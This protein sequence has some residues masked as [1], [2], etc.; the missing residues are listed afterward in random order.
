[1]NRT[2]RKTPIKSDKQAAAIVQK[3]TKTIVQEK[4]IGNNDKVLLGI[5]G[6]IDSTAL[7]FV[8]LEIQKTIDFEL[9]LAHIN[10]MLRSKES[11]RDERF[12]KKLAGRLRL[13]LYIKRVDIKKIAVEKGLSI[14]HAGR[15]ARYHFFNE[16]ITQ[17]GYDK[18]AI[19]H[20][21]D[22]QIETMLL[23]AL[24]GTGLRGLS[25]IPIKRNEIIR[26]FLNTYRTDIS[27]YAS[28]HS[29]LFVED[30]SNDKIVY[31][32]NFL[33]KEIFP[34]MEKLNPLFKEKLSF[35]LKDLT[36]IDHLFEEKSKSFLKKHQK[37]KAG[38]I[39]LDVLSLNKIDDETKFRVISDIIAS[40]EPAFVP[41]R[42]HIHQIKNIL[43]AKKPNLVATLPNGIKIKKIYDHLLFTKKPLSS[44][45]QET[46]L[47]SMGKNV[48][49]PFALNLHLS[50]P[51]K[52]VR[53]FSKNNNIALFD[54]EKLGNLTIRTFINGD[55][56]IPL[57]MKGKMKLKDFFI[58]SKIPK[59]ERRTIP[60]LLSD[61]D[62]I[63][64]LGLRINEGFKITKDTKKVLKV[65]IT[66]FK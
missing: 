39:S 4:L 50:Q 46:F 25:A 56:F 62:I 63:W 54:S 45:I 8:L 35:L 44:P 53:V 9:G 12:V 19:A 43:S 14:Q 7:L 33:R 61:N 15:E 17:Y 55:T 30:S 48:L 42:E 16:V 13:P 10:H 27:V 52:I 64:V 59:E 24:K 66:S 34:V 40:L 20:N 31:E 57:G 22:D 65:T 1:L 51:R 23:R 5:S 18:I 47:L 58:S 3:V 49:K 38:D 29:M 60:L 41:L 11:E 6:G 2:G 28:H 32:R 36:Y 37:N 21:L 26:P